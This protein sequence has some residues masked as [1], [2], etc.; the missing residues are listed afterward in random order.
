M[1]L[2]KCDNDNPSASF[3]LGVQD[4]IKPRYLIDYSWKGSS[5]VQ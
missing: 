2:V 4:K 1:L 5:L 3:I